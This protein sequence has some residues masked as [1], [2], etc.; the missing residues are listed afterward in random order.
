MFIIWTLDIRER[1]WHTDACITEVHKTVWEGAVLVVKIKYTEA[2]IKQHSSAGTLKV[3][4]GYHQSF[5]IKCCISFYLQDLFMFY[6]KIASN[7]VYV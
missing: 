2:F 4:T 6:D 3:N 5:I 1:N 7:P